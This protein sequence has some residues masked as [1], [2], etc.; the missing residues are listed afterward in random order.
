[1]SVTRTS[2][3]SHP[4]N[5][6]LWLAW[7]LLVAVL[8]L[9]G[10]VFRIATGSFLKIATK[11]IL[12]PVP[13]ANMPREIESWSGEDSPLSREVERIAGNDDYI[14]RLFVRNSTGEAAN[15]YVA[16]SGR[17]RTMVGHRPTVCYVN[18]GWVHV[19]TEKLVLRLSSGESLPCLFH[20]FQMPAPKTAEIYVLNYYVLNG[21]VT[22]DEESFAGF[23]WR[24]P[25]INGN[26]AWYVTQVQIASKSPA[27]ARSLAIDSAP[28]ILE[29]LPDKDGRVKATSSSAD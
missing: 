11:K 20:R 26:P 19:S 27:A 13:L 2:P 3:L 22:N 1:M 8:V 18:A 21:V 14:N 10:V 6:R 12:L 23:A 5:R 16:Y 7:G 28:L 9:G 25:N 29:Y 4:F 17:P 15:L 24:L